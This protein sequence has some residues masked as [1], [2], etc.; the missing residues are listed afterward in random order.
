LLHLRE[1]HRWSQK[2]LAAARGLSDYRPIS[3]YE[4]GDNQL[5][6]Q[7]L[8]VLAGLLGDSRETV[9]ALLFTDSLTTPSP[10]EPASPV[11]LTPAELRRID[12]A[13][14]A[15]GWTRA[16]DL[17]GKL[18]VD[19][20]RRK[21]KAARREAG[22]LWARLKTLS[23]EARREVVEDAP[24]FQTWALAEL[25]CHE[26]ERAAPNDAQEALHLADLALWIAG[27]VEGDE[28]CSRLCGYAWAYKGN[29]LRVS[30][31]LD[32]ADEAFDRA[33][34]LWKAGAGVDPTLLPEWRMLSLEATLRRVQHR[35][36]EALELLAR[37]E[38]GAG[39]E[40]AALATILLKREFVYEQMGDL[41]TALATLA[42]AAPYVKISGD[43]RLLSV[44][45]FETAKDLCALERFEEAATLMPGVR[46][47]AERLGNKLDIVRVGWLAARIDAGHGRREDAIAGLEQVR[48]E[49][50]DRLIP[51]DAA[52]SSLELSVLYLE[53]G[54]TGVV[55]A[56]AREMGAIFKSQG[57]AREALASL[58]VFLEAAQKET[59]TV[60]LARR[61]L[62]E[63]EGARRK[64]P[65]PMKGLRGL[66][67]ES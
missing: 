14:I 32:K 66:D 35:S 48:R 12:R 11:A 10:P 28:F 65:G 45:R 17:R 21:V 8:Y 13:V 37:A 3:R 62:A 30:G 61:V 9:D 20:K 40:P 52:R 43:A 22:V 23:R 4:T 51:Y 50:T 36:A 34:E 57:I 5:S 54:R 25:L 42:E 2:E 46:E 19:K 16:A 24:E 67:I 33:W 49:F 47:L 41:E 60:E 18:I 59:A 55:K 44:L 56:L 63:V 31:H 64:A 1:K 29:A 39:G 38:K 27:R 58:S 53:E 15:D 6:R 26:S 7:E